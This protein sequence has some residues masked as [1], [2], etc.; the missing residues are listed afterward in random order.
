[1]LPGIRMHMVHMLACA[2]HV[3][4]AGI[5]LHMKH[6]PTYVAYVKNAGVCVAH[7]AYV[8]FC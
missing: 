4:Y 2:A 8:G 3:A 6:T 1:M 5:L 7:A